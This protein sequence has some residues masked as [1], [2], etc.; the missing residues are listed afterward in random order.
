LTETSERIE[1]VGEIA[2]K[3]DDG[4][5]FYTSPLYEQQITDRQQR[6]RFDVSFQRSADYEHVDC[7]LV[8]RDGQVTRLCN[9]E[10]ADSPKDAQILRID[11]ALSLQI[12]DVDGSPLVRGK[13]AK[14][15][16]VCLGTFGAKSNALVQHKGVP[17][18]VH[19][20]AEIEFPGKQAGDQPIKTTI[21]L[22]QRCCGTLFHAPVRVPDEAG[23]GKARVRLSFAAWKEGKVAPAQVDVPVVDA[24]QGAKG[25]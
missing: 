5:T 15:L 17:A 10:M 20:V 18:D 13:E 1:I 23:E 6:R 25:S 11:G 4:Q 8:T 21:V 12:A 2:A 24:P 22:N 7:N 9:C 19:P 3:T 14:K 16:F